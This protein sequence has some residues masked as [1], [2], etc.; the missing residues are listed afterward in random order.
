MD[1]RGE[2]VRGDDVDRKDVRAA[3]D[4]G[5][6]DHRVDGAELVDLIG[7]GPRLVQVGQVADD[8]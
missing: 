3:V 8:G 5:V 4:A 7:H 2:Q 1:E 6:V